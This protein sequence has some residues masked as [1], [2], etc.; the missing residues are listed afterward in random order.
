MAGLSSAR[1]GYLAEKMMVS[2][3]EPHN[4]HTSLTYHTACNTTP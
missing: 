4:T 2:Y 1:V 3:N